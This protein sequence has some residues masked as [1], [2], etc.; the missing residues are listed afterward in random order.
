MIKDDGTGS[1]T[2][3]NSAGKGAA[4]SGGGA[5][6]GAAATN[7]QTSQSPQ[8][9]T[10]TA[11]TS[12]SS[13]GHKP[14]QRTTGLLIRKPSHRK[15]SG[16]V[17]EIRGAELDDYLAFCTEVEGASPDMDDVLE[18]ALAALFARAKGF[19][20]WRKKRP[21]DGELDIRIEDVERAVDSLIAPSQAGASG[22]GS[23]AQA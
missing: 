8:T 9:V 21:Q 4:A 11:Q 20:S 2:G 15:V 23:G 12:A 17:T 16:R 6:R 19:F 18:N 10:S 13:N 3:E 22:T 1:K 5:G 14:V 7:T